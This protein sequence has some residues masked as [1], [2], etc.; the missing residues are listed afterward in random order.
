MPTLPS[1]EG[2]V[3]W[4]YDN[5]M[6]NFTYAY[7]SGLNVSPLCFIALPNPLKSHAKNRTKKIAPIFLSFK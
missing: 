3:G 4:S 1:H 2:S 6:L 5:K 7:L